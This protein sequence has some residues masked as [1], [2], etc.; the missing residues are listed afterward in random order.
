M[1][2]RG[3]GSLF[4]CNIDLICVTMS[5]TSAGRVYELMRLHAIPFAPLSQICSPLS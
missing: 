3:T 5:H 2:G 4:L 1:V